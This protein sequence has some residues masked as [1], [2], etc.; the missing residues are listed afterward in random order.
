MVCVG[1]GVGLC[2]CWCWWDKED[3]IDGLASLL[4]LSFSLNA[5]KSNQNSILQVDNTGIL[6][7]CSTGYVTSKLTSCAR[8]MS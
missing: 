6:Q 2:W 1:G 5:K 7:V 4:M 8:T 3:K